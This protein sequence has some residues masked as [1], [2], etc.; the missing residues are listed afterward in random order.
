MLAS[1]DDDAGWEAPDAAE[2][3]KELCTYIQ[4]TVRPI[5]SRLVIMLVI[6]A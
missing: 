4:T 1:A 2:V 5:Y 6:N 3:S